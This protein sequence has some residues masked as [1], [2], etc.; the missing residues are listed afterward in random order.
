MN[1][2][3]DTSTDGQKSRGRP[4]KKEELEMDGQLRRCF[5]QGK[6]PWTA[7][8]ETCHSVNTVRKYYKK[9]YTE[10][11][12]AE[13]PEFVQACKE[14]VISTRLALEEQLTKMQLMQSEME[15]ASPQNV[16]HYIQ[17][18]KLKIGLNREITDLHLKIL[19]I[20]NTPTVDEI[21]AAFRKEGEMK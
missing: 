21:L 2:I 17:I 7:S 8:K 12:T 5:L 19:N 18:C 15:K 9:Y 20:A 3:D 4:S 11:I 6:S 14:R 10:T 16:T 1:E 13:A